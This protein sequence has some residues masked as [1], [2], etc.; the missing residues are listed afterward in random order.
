MRKIVFALS[1]ALAL[2][3]CTTTQ[4]MKTATTLKTAAEARTI[5]IADLDV[6]PERVTY[7]YTPSDDVQRGGED[8]VRRAAEAAVLAQHGNAD[9]LLDAQYVVKKE[10]GFLKRPK[11]TSI[12]VSGHPAHYRNFRPVPESVWENAS[13]AVTSVQAGEQ[14]LTNEPLQKPEEPKLK[15]PNLSFNGLRFEAHLNAIGGFTFGTSEENAYVGGLLT[16]GCRVMPQLFVGVGSGASYMFERKYV[17]VPVYGNVRWYFMKKA[18]T[19]FIDV[20]AGY[21]FIPK[22]SDHDGGFYLSPTIGYEFGRFEVGIQYTF[23]KSK[24]RNWHDYNA[25]CTDHGIGLSLGFRF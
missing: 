11:V 10:G 9:V 5:T 16:L 1:A 20:K 22:K 14:E 21:S 18:N 23:Q 12:T 2:A 3:S 7:T 17:F 15:L 4:T 25:S 24:E 6:A 8:N 19:P 13:L